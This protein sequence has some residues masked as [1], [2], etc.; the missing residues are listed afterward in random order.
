LPEPIKHV[1]RR[2]QSR[3]AAAVAGADHAWPPPV[4]I[5]LQASSTQKPLVGLLYF[6]F[7]F[8]LILSAPMT[9]STHLEQQQLMEDGGSMIR[10]AH[11]VAP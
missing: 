8:L 7:F 6:F 11:G 9:S 2:S 5:E 1:R 10:E 4:P 3:L